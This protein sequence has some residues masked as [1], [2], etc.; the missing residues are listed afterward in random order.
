MLV[1]ALL[2]KFS[3]FHLWGLPSGLCAVG[4]GCSLL[5]AGWLEIDRKCVTTFVIERLHPN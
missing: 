4:G 2:I 3:V 1:Y 5:A